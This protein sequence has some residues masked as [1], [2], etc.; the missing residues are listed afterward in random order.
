MNSEKKENKDPAEDAPEWLKTFN[1]NMSKDM[2]VIITDLLALCGRA[3]LI[4]PCIW[5]T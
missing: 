3:I 2:M 5:S 4:L 1:E